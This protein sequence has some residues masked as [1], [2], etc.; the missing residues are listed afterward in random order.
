MDNRNLLMTQLSALRRKIVEAVILRKQ[1]QK[2]VAQMYGFTESTVSQYVQAFKIDGESSLVYQKRGRKPQTC[3]KLPV[4]DEIDIQNAIRQNTPDVFGLPCVLWT[5]KAVCE[6]IEERYHVKYSVRGIGNTL[7]RWGFTPQKPLK[8]AIQR[9]PQKVKQWLEVDY[10]AIKKR[11]QQEGATIFWGDEMGLSSTDQRGRTYGKKGET[12]VIRKTGSRY[13]C[14]MI[15]A[16]T[17]HGTM[18]WMV[19]E[20]S[21]TVPIFLQFLRR[22][23]YKS[24]KK[25]FL[26]VDNLKVHHAKKVREWLQENKDKIEIFFLPPYCPEMNPQEL[27]NQEVKSH[28]S[29]FKLV[30]S[31]NELTINLRYYLTKIQFNPWKVMGYFRKSSVSYAA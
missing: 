2:T 1:K 16:I 24:G 18:K 3:S 13:R 4:K 8:V 5:R 23:I 27:V 28:A 14:N 21:F 9:N 26:I 12:P 7:K 6:Y 31:M 20:D 15:S 17:N 19:F 25:I 30:A 22:L 29:N 10:P 11:A